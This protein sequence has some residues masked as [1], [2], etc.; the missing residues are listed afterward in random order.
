MSFKRFKRHAVKGVDS[1]ID[2]LIC[3][4]ISV[5]FAFIIY[6]LFKSKSLPYV[7]TVI[8]LF[9]RIIAG[10]FFYYS[11]ILWGVIFILLGFISDGADG[12]ISRAIY[13]KDPQLRG[14]LDFIFDHISVV[15]IYV[16]LGNLI[17]L[18]APHLINLYIFSL[19]THI[20]LM[21]MTSTKF[22]LNALEGI[23][24]ERTLMSTG[25]I[26]GK[27]GIAVSY[28]QRQFGKFGLIMHPCV[29][30]SNIILWVLFPLL[31]FNVWILIIAV[32]I[33]WIDL[34]ISG[35]TPIYFLLKK[36]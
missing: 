5:I 14:T 28:I 23:N 33:L 22:R 31:N 32:L 24:P 21:A 35:I 30:D 1:W 29:G 3:G 17:L 4:H 18:N 26:K 34:L 10:V 20:L 25:I 7:I 11:N 16:G 12:Q 9:F 6:K 2:T 27:V 13:G 15:F 36:S 8:T 19:S